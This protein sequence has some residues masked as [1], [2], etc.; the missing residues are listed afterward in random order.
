MLSSQMRP[1]KLSSKGDSEGHHASRTLPLAL[2][3]RRPVA[4][5]LTE[6]TAWMGMIWRR[7]QVAGEVNLDWIWGGWR[8]GRAFR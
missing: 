6:D 8:W 3:L 5:D 1:R 4:C 7:C 2:A